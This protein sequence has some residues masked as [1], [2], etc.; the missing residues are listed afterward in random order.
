MADLVL[1]STMANEINGQMLE[2]NRTID[3]VAYSCENFMKEMEHIFR[4]SRVEFTQ[5]SLLRKDVSKATLCRLLVNCCGF[6]SAHTGQIN[7]LREELACCEDENRTLKEEAGWLKTATI[8][9]QQSVIGLQ[10][11]LLECKNKKLESVQSAVCNV[12]AESVKSEMKSYSA[13]AATANKKISA[14]EIKTFTKA[15]KLVVQEEDRSKNII[16]FGL[17]ESV[18]EDT[19]SV[20]DKVFESVGEKPRHDSV[21]IGSRPSSKAERH[22]PVKVRLADSSHVIQILRSAKKLKETDTYRK[23]FLSPDRSLEERKLR[24]EAVACLKKKLDAEPNSR[25]FIKDGKVVS[26]KSD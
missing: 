6:I 7:Q 2:L 3:S 10:T 18:D 9:A 14:P 20:I 25:H 5:T 19:N 24:R 17:Q 8:N 11:E 21:R 15:M 26:V 22:R 16:V 4:S 13:V 1:N 12:V 23:V